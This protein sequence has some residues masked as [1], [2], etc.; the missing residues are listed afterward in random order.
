[1]SHFTKIQ[2]CF[3]LGYRKKFHGGFWY[4]LD[5]EKDFD[6]G[7]TDDDANHKTG[8]GLFAGGLAGI[9]RRDAAACNQPDCRPVQRQFAGE[10]GQSCFVRPGGMGKRVPH[11]SGGVSP[12]GPASGFRGKLLSVQGDPRGFGG[13]HLFGKDYPQ[14][15]HH[16]LEQRDRHFLAH[17]AGRRGGGGYP[18]VW[19]FG[20]SGSVRQR[21]CGCHRHLCGLCGSL[22]RPGDGGLSGGKRHRRYDRPGKGGENLSVCGRL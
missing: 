11:P 10:P 22:R 2:C 7:G 19:L 1:M 4:N 14:V 5:I 17:R 21:L 20:G 13:G 18:A 6:G 3:W 9:H 8:G 16:V 15:H 12:I